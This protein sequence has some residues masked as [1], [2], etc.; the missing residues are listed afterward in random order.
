MAT[1]AT[2]YRLQ[3]FPYKKKAAYA[4]VS[5]GDPLGD[6]VKV[7]RL[8]VLGPARGKTG[9]ARKLSNLETTW[10]A[11]HVDPT[12]IEEC[13]SLGLI[14]KDHQTEVLLLSLP[15]MSLNREMRFELHRAMVGDA[16]GWAATGKDA[17]LGNDSLETL[18]SVG[19]PLTW[20]KKEYLASF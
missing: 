18:I 14:G 6:R 4:Y 5:W 15:S 2:K 11:M 3:H 8:K 12:A 7:L 1:A 10:L 17:H 9:F 19:E 16:V 20:T 13:R